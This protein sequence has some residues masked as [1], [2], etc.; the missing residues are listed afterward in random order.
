MLKAPVMPNRLKMDVIIHGRSHVFDLARALHAR[1]HNVRLLTNN[2]SSVVARFWFPRSR[3]EARVAEGIA[4]RIY[5]RVPQSLRLV[6]WN[7]LCTNGSG[8]GLAP[9]LGMMPIGAESLHGA[10]GPPV[11]VARGSSDIRVQRKLSEEEELWTGVQ[12]K[13]QPL[14]DIEEGA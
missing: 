8:A 6:V 10:G 1:G 13:T 9:K 11:R 5:H 2:P 7:R 12:L 14:D 3:A 4:A